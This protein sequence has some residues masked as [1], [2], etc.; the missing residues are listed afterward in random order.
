VRL[1]RRKVSFEKFFE[2]R[3]IFI[4]WYIIINMAIV[5]HELISSL[6]LI[7]RQ[8]HRHIKIFN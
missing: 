5:T 4:T 6:S 7:I 8:V 2:F 1:A 3:Q